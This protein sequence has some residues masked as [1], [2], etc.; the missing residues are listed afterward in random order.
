MRGDHNL[1]AMMRRRP[2]VRISGASGGSA[3]SGGRA[4]HAPCERA[5]VARRAPT[6]GCSKAVPDVFSVG[7]PTGVHCVLE[8]TRGGANSNQQRRLVARGGAQ[9]CGGSSWGT[10]V[11]SRFGD[12]RSA[13][14]GEIGWDSERETA[15]RLSGCAHCRSGV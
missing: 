3:R 4:R 10:G 11:S 6:G 9:A 5:V 8:V 2:R 12:R 1:A 13:M 15:T 7:V 14:L